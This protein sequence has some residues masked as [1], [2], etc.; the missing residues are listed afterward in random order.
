MLFDMAHG[1]DSK[2]KSLQVSAFLVSFPS[3]KMLSGE[4][5]SATAP[6]QGLEWWLEYLLG[7]LIRAQS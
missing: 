5:L 6:F 2:M 7:S 3:A 1:T 4:A